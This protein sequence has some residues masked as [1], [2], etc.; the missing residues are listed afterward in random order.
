MIYLLYYIGIISDRPYYLIRSEISLQL[1]FLVRDPTEIQFTPFN[2]YFDILD[3]LIFPEISMGFVV[4]WRIFFMLGIEKLSK[5]ILSTFLL[6]ATSLNS[7]IF[8]TSITKNL[9]FFL[10]FN[11]TSSRLSASLRWFS[12]SKIDEEIYEVNNIKMYILSY[13]TY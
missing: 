10:A 3:K 11:K 7:L 6:S 8:E 5:R 12:L 4:I 9:F 13:Y 1:T 2:V